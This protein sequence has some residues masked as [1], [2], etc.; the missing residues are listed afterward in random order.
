MAGAASLGRRLIRVQS[1]HEGRAAGLHPPE[2]VAGAAQNLMVGGS[3]GF[4]LARL[5]LEYE[6]RKRQNARPRLARLD[7]NFVTTTAGPAAPMPTLRKQKKLDGDRLAVACLAWG[8]AGLPV[9]AFANDARASLVLSPQGWQNR[10]PSGKE[11]RAN[12][13]AAC[14]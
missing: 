14:R 8:R 5:A 3:V 13:T 4:S 11:A 9:V 10:R 6:D 12:S 7:R 1:G 2:R